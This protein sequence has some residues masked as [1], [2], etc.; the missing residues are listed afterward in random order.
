M[1]GLRRGAPAPAPRL[2]TSDD[3][4]ALA[5]AGRRSGM[6]VAR[7]PDGWLRVNAERTE[8]DHYVVELGR[9]GVAVRRLELMMT[10]LES[11]FLTLTGTP[12][13]PATPGTSD[14]VEPA[15]GAP[16]PPQPR[17]GRHPPRGSPGA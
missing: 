6:Q 16:P 4:R 13:T 7:E 2:W 8:L 9:D 12:M 5:V 15:G 3:V 10:P 14:A 1:R 17:P 11:M